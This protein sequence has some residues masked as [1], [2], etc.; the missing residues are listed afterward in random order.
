M[1]ERQNPP[2]FAAAIAKGWR[3][4][5][6]AEVQASKGL[7]GGIHHA[8]LDQGSVCYEGPCSDDGERVICYLN[9]DGESCDEN[10]TTTSAGCQ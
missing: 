5:T 2:T 6:F 8:N 7:P 1:E 10:C 9:D 3:K 4:A